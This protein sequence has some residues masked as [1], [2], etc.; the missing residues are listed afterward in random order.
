MTKNKLNI[1]QASI[2][3]LNK[4]PSARIE[5][6]ADNAGVSRRTLHRYFSTRDDLL[7][8]CAAWIMDEVL[9]DVTNATQ[10]HKQPLERLK[11]IFK[12]DISKGQYFEFCQKFV[13][14][15]EDKVIQAKFNQMTQLFQGA[16][17]QTKAQGI[18]DKALSNEWIEYMWMG[19][20]HGATRALAEGAVAPKAVHE[21]AWNT[22]AHGLINQTD[23]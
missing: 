17:D 11:Q 5:T 8:A 3:V 13:A 10:T 6:I 20:V 16:L 12:D 22:F 9:N 21:L 15:F 23:K 18:I 7:A 4:D 1:I 14:H 19:I 2:I